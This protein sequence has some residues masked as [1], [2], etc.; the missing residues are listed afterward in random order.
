[1]RVKTQLQEAFG[2]QFSQ[3]VSVMNDLET[4]FI[5]YKAVYYYSEQKKIM[6]LVSIIDDTNE[7][8]GH[9]LFSYFYLSIFFLLLLLNKS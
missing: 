8:V 1:M 7:Q 6:I 4:N 5:L 3:L 9:T 2:L